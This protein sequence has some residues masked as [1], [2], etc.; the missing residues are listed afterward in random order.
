MSDHF[1]TPSEEL[2]HLLNQI[3]DIKTTLR[4]IA[5]RVA[6]I[7]QHVK[8]AFGVTQPAVRQSGATPNAR[9]RPQL[10]PSSLSGEQAQAIFD[11]LP[12]L[13]STRGREGV[14]GRLAALEIQ[15][16]KLIAQEV[17]VPLPNK[18]SRRSLISVIVQRAAESRLLSTNRNLPRTS[19]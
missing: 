3:G 17:G 15:D 8:R 1:R 10:P 5:G 7:E 14:E 2:Q 4:E 6:Q 9:S 18:P 13:L 16:L 11:E 19:N 12:R